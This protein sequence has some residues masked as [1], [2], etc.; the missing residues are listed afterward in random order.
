MATP[1]PYN[2]NGFYVLETQG[3]PTVTTTGITFHFLDH[4]FV[5]APYN[6]DV[7]IHVTTP[8]PTGTTGTLP[9]FFQSGSRQPRAVTK[10]GGGPLTAADLL[11]TGYYKLFY[12]FNRGVLET[13]A[14]VV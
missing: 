2:R 10:A 9:V 11:N 7:T 13:Y 1:R 3:A 6:G 4:P 8:T 12:D 5:N 14:R